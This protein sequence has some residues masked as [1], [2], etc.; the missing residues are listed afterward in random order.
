[1]TM[2]KIG[3]MQEFPRAEKRRLKVA[4][5]AARRRARHRAVVEASTLAI[6]RETAT[7]WLAPA[8]RER[9]RA[10][11]RRADRRGRAQRGDDRAA[12]YRAGKAPQ[13]ELIAAQ[14]MLIELRNRATDAATQAQARAHRARPLRRRRRDAPARRCAGF[15]PPARRRAACRHRRAAGAPPRPRAGLGSPRPKPRIARAAKKPDWSAEVSYAY[16][17]APYANMV[18]LMFSID[19]PW[20]QGTRQDRE[21]AAKLKRAD[22]ARAM[23]ED[24]QRMRARG[25]A[26]RCRPNGN[27][28]ARRRTHR[29]RAH[30]AGG[31]APRGGASGLSR[32]HRHARRGARRA[33][34]RAR[35][36]ALAHQ[37]QQA[38]G[39][40][41]AWLAFVFPATEES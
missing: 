37:Q 18:S 12:A 8:F 14:S 36:R 16:R 30:P 38:A 41:W 29:D 7:A 21:H 22:A 2:S 6:E 28:H 24:T 13:S 33:A 27:R 5:R 1:M 15:R 35:R 20:S 31:A 32:R 23:R 9:G 26:S 25:G 10:R 19:L 11:D 34:R 40:A 39:K 17:G 4:A 3:L